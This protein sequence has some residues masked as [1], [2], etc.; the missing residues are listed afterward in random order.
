[1]KKILISILFLSISIFI[2]CLVSV[3]NLKIYDRFL[4]ETD[5]NCYGKFWIT[6]KDENQAK[7]AESDYGI[8]LPENDYTKFNFIVTDGR[9]I[10]KIKYHL[11]SRYI[12]EY[13]VPKGEA[14]FTEEYYENY[15]ICYRTEKIFLKQEGE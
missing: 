9:A 13:D 3:H 2:L 7:K 14:E 11:F 1:M 6:I 5:R 10:K 8:T 4:L 15:M 12:W